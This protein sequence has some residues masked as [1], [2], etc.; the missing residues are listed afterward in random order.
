MGSAVKRAASDCD[1]GDSRIL[2]EMNITKKKPTGFSP[3][4]LMHTWK[5][6]MN[7]NEEDDALDDVIET[8]DAA[9]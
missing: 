6:R 1:V 3:C 7:T 8:R 9:D 4:E 2:T 5:F